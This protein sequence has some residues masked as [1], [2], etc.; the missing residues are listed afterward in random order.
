MRNILL[1]ILAL[2]VVTIASADTLRDQLKQMDTKVSAA[3]VKKDFV[4]F[5]AVLKPW[6]A[7]D[8]VYSEPGQKPMN[9]DKMVAGMKM[10]LGMMS[11]VTLAKAT[12][13][14]LKETG[15]MATA[16]SIHKMAGTIPGGKGGKMHTMA[17]TGVSTETYEKVNGKWLMKSMSM[18]TTEMSMDG[19]PMPMPGGMR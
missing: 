5:S 13:S 15:T 9:F 18:R 7:P 14:N 1:P 6:V 10:G 3:L 8:F 11:K 2:G 17:Y 4:S 16:T 19:K 12:L